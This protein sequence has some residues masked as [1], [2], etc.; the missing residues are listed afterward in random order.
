MLSG[1]VA[2]TQDFTKPHKKKL[3][4]VRFGDCG[5]DSISCY[6]ATTRST[7]TSANLSVTAKML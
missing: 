2:N 4:R 5:G 7:K 6:N 1:G 3:H